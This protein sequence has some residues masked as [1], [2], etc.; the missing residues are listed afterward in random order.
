MSS[1]DSWGVE[2]AEVVWSRGRVLLRDLRPQVWVVLHDLALDAE[3]R[4]GRLVASSS[5]RLVVDLERKC[6]GEFLER[7]LG[8]VVEPKR[9]PR[10]SARRGWSR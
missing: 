10:R 3:W 4:D 5:A 8:G 9:R 1:A 7:P 6:L 2:R